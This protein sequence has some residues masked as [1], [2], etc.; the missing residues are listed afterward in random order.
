MS[1]EVPGNGQSDPE[2]IDYRYLVLVCLFQPS[3]VSGVGV[4]AHEG[5]VH[6]VIIFEYLAMNFSLVIIP[7]L[8]ARLRKYCLDRQ[9]EPHLLWLENASLRIDQ[10]N[11]RPIESRTPA[12]ILQR[13]DGR[14]ISFRSR[15]RSKAASRLSVSRFGVSIQSL[16]RLVAM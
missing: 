8:T 5:V 12:L 9:K 10:W 2:K 4:L 16:A 1:G 15:T 11:A 7:D 13:S 14:E 6:R 3:I